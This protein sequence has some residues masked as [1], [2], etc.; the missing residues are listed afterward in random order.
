VWVPLVVLVG[1]AF[2][3]R[4]RG[5][6]AKGRR[7]F[8]STVHDYRVHYGRRNFMRWG[9]MVLGAAVLAYGGVDERFDR[10]HQDAVRSEATDAVARL[11]HFLG[12][13]FWFAYWAVFALLDATWNSTPLTRWG[14]LS[15]EAMVVGLPSLWATQRLLGASRPGEAAHG[16]RLK[17][18]ADDNAASGHTFIAAIPWL[19]AARLAGKRAPRA[20]AYAMSPLTGWSRINDGQHY[21]SQVALGYALAWGAV[22][23]VTEHRASTSPAMLEAETT[24]EPPPR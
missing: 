13:R 7:L 23:T 1:V 16:P 18:F 11:F 2:L 15:F 10:W 8:S 17:P 19:V 20:A 3:W 21:L 22:E 4:A 6:R 24:E 9:A 12:E 5:G 14:R